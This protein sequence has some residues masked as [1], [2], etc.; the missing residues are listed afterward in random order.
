MLYSEHPSRRLTPCDTPRERAT[1]W[2]R[3]YQPEGTASYTLAEGGVRL[4]REACG[5]V[6]SEMMNREEQWRDN[7]WHKGRQGRRIRKE[8][9]EREKMEEARG[10]AQEYRACPALQI[11]G[12]VPGG[13]VRFPVTGWCQSPEPKAS[14]SGQLVRQDCLLR[15]PPEDSLQHPLT[16]VK[17]RQPDFQHQKGGKEPSLAVG[18]PTLKMNTSAPGKGGTESLKPYTAILQR[19]HSTHKLKALGV[20]PDARDST[21]LNWNEQ[22]RQAEFVC[23]LVRTP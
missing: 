6:F 2:D 10:R 12:A 16:E 17:G 8:G 13:C 7:G 1:G 4:R 9:W 23:T 22:R 5:G 14:P 21:G 3:Q 19:A 11:R 20:F 18:A 15:K